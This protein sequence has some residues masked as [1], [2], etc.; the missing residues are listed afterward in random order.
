MLPFPGQCQAI[1]YAY[2]LANVTY[3][4]LFFYCGRGFHA[5]RFRLTAAPG[6]RDR[7]VKLGPGRLFQAQPDHRPTYIPVSHK[8]FKSCF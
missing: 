2:I 4:Y 5:E 7:I 8:K 3:A 6:V 1:V